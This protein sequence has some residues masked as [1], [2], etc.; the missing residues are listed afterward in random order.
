MGWNILKSRSNFWVH[1]FCSLLI[2]S[3]SKIYYIEILNHKTFYLMINL[4]NNSEFRWVTLDLLLILKVNLRR[5]KLFVVLLV[6]L[7]L[8]YSQVRNLAR[9]QIYLVSDVFSISLWQECIFSTEETKMK[10]TIK[11]RKWDSPT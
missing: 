9:S 8:K 11:T 10:F 2:T 6:I 4:W 3:I 7:H 5:K 1:N